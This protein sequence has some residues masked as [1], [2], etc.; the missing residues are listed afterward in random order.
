MNRL[1]FNMM[2]KARQIHMA[3]IATAGDEN[4]LNLHCPLP[5]AHYFTNPTTSCQC[6]LDP[7]GGKAN[8]GNRKNRL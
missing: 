3:E 1:W 4:G 5:T 6:F 7:P 2:M 8:E